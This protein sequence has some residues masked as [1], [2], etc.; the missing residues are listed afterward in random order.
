MTK[1]A[2]NN[3]NSLRISFFLSKLFL[4]H[5]A[6]VQ[7]NLLLPNPIF[8]DADFL[9]KTH[10]IRLRQVIWRHLAKASVQTVHI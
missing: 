6:R 3:L 4:S 2:Q 8:W 9:S 7:P 1:I 5:I 10:V